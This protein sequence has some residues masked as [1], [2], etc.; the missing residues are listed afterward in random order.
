MPR[1]AT[2]SR[3]DLAHPGAERLRSPVARRRP[4]PSRS[5]VVHVPPRSLAGPA[6]S[7]VR[8]QSRRRTGGRSQPVATAVARPVVGR[9]PAAGQL[10]GRHE[11]G[12]RR[13]IIG[14]PAARR[15]GAEFRRAAQPPDATE[16]EHTF[17]D[18]PGV[19]VRLVLTYQR[20]TEGRPSPCRFTPTCSSYALEALQTHGR[21]RGLALT[22]RRLVRCRPFGPSGWDP[23]PDA[24]T[25]KRAAR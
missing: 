18:R 16:H 1:A 8:D 20:A 21:G 15:A 23:V 12:S 6:S 13:T 17:A 22:A 3:L 7:G 14:R 19:L 11:A 25:R 24:P 9:R 5:A 2:S 4:H 10:P